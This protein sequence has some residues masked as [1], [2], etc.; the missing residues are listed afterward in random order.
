MVQLTNCVVDLARR[1][2]RTARHTLPLTRREAELLTYLSERP[3]QVVSREDLMREVWGYDATVLSRAVDSAVCRLRSKIESDP[4]HPEHLLT[5]HGTGYRFVV[6]PRPTVPV[7]ACAE[8]PLL[9]LSGGSVDLT[10]GDV[11]RPDGRITLTTSE[12][13]LLRELVCTAGRSIEKAQLERRV[14]GNV[15]AGSARLRNVICRLRAKIERDPAEPVHLLVGLKGH[16]YRFVLPERA[17][18]A[19]TVT[20]VMGDV[21]GSVAADDDLG[22]VVERLWAHGVRVA[23]QHGGYPSSVAGGRVCLVF[24]RADA[25]VR[26]ALQLG[27][28][29]RVGLATGVVRRF[30][31]PLSQRFE[32]VGAPVA[33]AAK[34]CRSLHLGGLGSIED[35]ALERAASQPVLPHQTTERV[36]AA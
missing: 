26:A 1:S 30:V 27:R 32:Y 21:A 3:S 7:S 4:L 22:P 14:W 31:N 13:A 29:V 6:G 23:G 36:T 34:R 9:A 8:A 19:G 12:L 15:V 5:E 35:Q 33:R 2:V 18:P 20:I 10:C 24:A 16:G 17:P 28:E 11:F 25:A